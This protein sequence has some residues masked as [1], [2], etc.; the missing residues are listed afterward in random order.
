MILACYDIARRPT[1]VMQRVDGMR[2]DMSQNV[3][4]TN[5]FAIQN[6]PNGSKI[7]HRNLER[8]GFCVFAPLLEL[9]Q[10]RRGKFVTILQP[11]FHGYMFVQFDPETA[12]WRSINGT[13]GVSRLVSLDTNSKPTMIPPSLIAELILR[14]DKNGV[15][16]DVLPLAQGDKV[17]I[18]K[19]PFAEFTARVTRLSSQE[20]VWVLLDIMGGETALRLPREILETA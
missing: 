1:T 3:D 16:Q 17:R 15:F 18:T 14:C 8:Q 13:Y 7:A 11:L 5:W 12:P 2:N 10:K 19:G 9:T 6:K 20:R 4:P